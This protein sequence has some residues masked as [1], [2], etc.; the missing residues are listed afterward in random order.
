M[1]RERDGVCGGGV[2]GVGG[3]WV[4]SPEMLLNWSEFQ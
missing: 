3:G 1:E 4:C 2:S